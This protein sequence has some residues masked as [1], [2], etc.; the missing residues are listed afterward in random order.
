[1]RF[2][3]YKAHEH[4]L[5]APPPTRRAAFLL[6]TNNTVN[7]STELVLDRQNQRRFFYWT[8]LLIL[9][10]IAGVSSLLIV[11]IFIFSLRKI[12]SNL[13]ILFFIPTRQQYQNSVQEYF[14]LNHKYQ[15]LRRDWFNHTTNSTSPSETLSPSYFTLPLLRIPNQHIILFTTAIQTESYSSRVPQVKIEVNRPIWVFR[16]ERSISNRSLRD[17]YVK[18]VPNISNLHTILI[19]F[20]FH[21]RAI[22]LPNTSILT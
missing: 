6:N 4:Q 5:A 2:S 20:I 9:V 14:S 12:E 7:C 21:Q 3:K 18:S 16:I 1:M 13:N 8:A 17:S 15:Y 19:N 11:I 10:A 22:Y